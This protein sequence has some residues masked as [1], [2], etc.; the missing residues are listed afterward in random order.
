MRTIAIL[1]TYNE[2]RFIR[3]IIDHYNSHDVELYLIDNC[4]ADGTVDIARPF[5]GH[6]VCGIESF[7]RNGVFSLAAI[8]RRK[9]ELASTLD[10]DWFMHI[11]A[12]EFIVPPHGKGTLS[13]AF[14][15]AEAAGYNCVQ[16]HEFTFVPTKESPQHDHPD[17]QRT[18]L[19]YYPFSPSFTHGVR[20][21]KRQP[22]GVE[23]AWSAGHLP[24]FPDLRIS[25][26]YFLM[27]HYQF[28]SREHVV[29]K[30][31]NRVYDPNAVKGGWHGWRATLRSDQIILRSQSELKTYTSDDRLDSSDARTRHFL[32]PA[33]LD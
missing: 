22:G 3:Q 32:D 18:M 11:D 30:Y 16:F 31:V 5:L 29:E 13:V 8:L 10:G 15:E 9:E 19:W 17:F 24:R 20:A 4:S 27:R 1:A 26:R 12:D 7:A 2:R 28:L 14:S 6:G 21:W 25:P 33:C 23:I